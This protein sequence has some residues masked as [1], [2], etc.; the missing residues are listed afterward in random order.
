METKPLLCRLRTFDQ[1]DNETLSPV[2]YIWKETLNLEGEIFV[3]LIEPDGTLLLSEI[4]NIK[5]N[6]DSCAG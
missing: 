4:S 5:V 2:V 1:D 6:M 3:L